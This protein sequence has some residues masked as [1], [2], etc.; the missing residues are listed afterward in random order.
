M[1]LQIQLCSSYHLQRRQV[2]EEPLFH[3][4]QP[5]QVDLEVQERTLEVQEWTQPQPQPLEAREGAV[6][7][8]E[9]DGGGWD[10][11]DREEEEEEALELEGPLELQESL[12]FQ[13]PLELQ[14]PIVFK[15]SLELQ[16]SF[17]IQDTLKLQGSQP[18]QVGHAQ[19]RRA[20]PLQ[21]GNSQQGRRGREPRRRKGLRQRQ[22]LQEGREKA[23]G[24]DRRQEVGEFCSAAYLVFCA[25]QCI[26][27][28]HTCPV[29][30]RQEG[31]HQV[32][33]VQG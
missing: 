15:D 29:E 6:L 9:D 30:V 13:D 21:V 28:I 32:R 17:V 31:Q 16:G 12:V 10:H 4:P 19:V 18:F 25:L 33:L 24:D 3:E 7:L 2:P 20:Q 5:V 22:H 23:G 8:A 11:H 14:G 27:S 1:I 26:F